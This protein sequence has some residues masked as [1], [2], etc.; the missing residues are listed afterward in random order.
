[1]LGAQQLPGELDLVSRC[2]LKPG[3]VMSGLSACR[4]M[5]IANCQPHVPH[6]GARDAAPLLSSHPPQIPPVPRQ[7]LPC[8]PLLTFVLQ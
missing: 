5:L 2:V 7:C 8:T 1:M 3:R 4:K 6:Q